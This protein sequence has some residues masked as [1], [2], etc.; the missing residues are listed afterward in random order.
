[1]TATA[2]SFTRHFIRSGTNSIHSNFLVHHSGKELLRAF[3][4]GRYGN[5][6]KRRGTASPA[7]LLSYFFPFDTDPLGQCCGGRRHAPAWLI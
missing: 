5:T 2:F 6:E 1:M 3:Q 7:E 4:I